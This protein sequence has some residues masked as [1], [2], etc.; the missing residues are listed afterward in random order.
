MRDIRD[1]HGVWWSLVCLTSIVGLLCAYAAWGW[2]GLGVAALTVATFAAMIGGCACAER[3][4][5]GGAE[6][7]QLTLTA[8]LILTAVTGLFAVLHAYALCLV[9]PLVATSPVVTYVVRK[10]VRGPDG[11]HGSPLSRAATS[12]GGGSQVEPAGHELTGTVPPDVRSLDDASLCL[13][14]RQSFVRLSAARSTADRLSVVEQRQNYLDELHRRSPQGVLAWFASGG[15]A[16]GNPL[17]YLGRRSDAD[18]WKGLTPPDAGG[19]HL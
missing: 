10:F 13:A 11:P 2:Q 3:G 8:G 19:A 6:A 15:R 18:P 9:V 12:G 16:S 14:W 1:H 5:R 4:R 7:T 17:P